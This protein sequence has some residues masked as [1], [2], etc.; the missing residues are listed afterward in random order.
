MSSTITK[1]K[2]ALLL[3][4]LDEFFPNPSPSLKASTSYTFLIAVLLSARCF[5]DRVNRV[6]DILFQKADS[7]NLMIQMKVEEIREIIRPCG[8]S[9]RKANA[10]WNLSSLLLNFHSGDVPDNRTDLEA[11]PGV[12][13]KTA[14]VVLSQ[15]FGHNA[16]PVDTHIFRCSRRWNM[17]NSKSRDGVERELMRLIPERLWSRVHLQMI[18]AGRQFCKSRMHQRENCPFC[19]ILQY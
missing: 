16:F 12:G 19:S 11:L 14:S 15:W 9:M 5:D 6:T 17:A 18:A 3:R 1:N 2:L 13:R 4:L 8:L 10:I 7:P